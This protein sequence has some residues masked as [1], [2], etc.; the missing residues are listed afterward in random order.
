MEFNKLLLS[1][2]NQSRGQWKVALCGD[3]SLMCKTLRSPQMF[4]AGAKVA[5]AVDLYLASS[6]KVARIKEVFKIYNSQK[7][8]SIQTL[9]AIQNAILAL[10]RPLNQDND[11]LVENIRTSVD[12]FGELYGGGIPNSFSIR[13]TEFS[14]S[15]VHPLLETLRTLM[16]NSDPVGYWIVHDMLARW[17]SKID[18]TPFVATTAILSGISPD[19]GDGLFHLTVELYPCANGP[20][21]PDPLYLGLTRLD[22]MFSDSITRLWKLTGLSKEYRARWRIETPSEEFQMKDFASVHPT[23]YSGRSAEAAFLCAMVAA[24]GNPYC[25]SALE[26]RAAAGEPL[27]IRVAVSATVESQGQGQAAEVTKLQLGEVAKV[28]EKLEHAMGP[29]HTV[30]YISK[31]R[32]NPTIAAILQA[33][34]PTRTGLAIESIETV[35][36]ALDVLLLTNRY[37]RDHQAAVRDAWLQQWESRTARFSGDT[38]PGPDDQN[39]RVEQKSSS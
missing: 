14:P 26:G 38:D 21:Y 22:R 11:R 19:I 4:N 27:D 31:Q 10:V 13:S 35:G 36:D 17:L 18:P 16:D 34:Q 30:A 39:V 6:L 7:D 1:F 5:A 12:G 25:E 32:S 24:S 8:P 23:V 37:L 20:I 3:Q 2:E 15:A 29:L 33:Q 9:E 28:P